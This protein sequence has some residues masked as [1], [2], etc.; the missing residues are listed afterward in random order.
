LL[1][2]IV[3]GFIRVNVYETTGFA[4]NAVQA[5][6]DDA[7]KQLVG[8]RLTDQVIIRL[9]GPLQEAEPILSVAILEAVRT[10]QFSQILRSAAVDA[11]R[12][13]FGKDTGNPELD[14]SDAGPLI[15]AVVERVDPGLADAL[16]ATIEGLLVEVSTKPQVTRLIRI[17]EDARD[18]TF[19]WPSLAIGLFALGILIAPNRRRCVVAVGVVMAVAGLILLVGAEALRTF[20]L[21]ERTGSTEADAARAIADAYLDDAPV[22]GFVIAVAGAVLA[23]AAISAGHPGE[24]VRQLRRVSHAITSRPQSPWLQILRGLVAGAVAVFVLFQRDL[25]V[26]IAVVVAGFLLLLYALT[27][28]MRA[29]ERV[30][31]RA[32]GLVPWLVAFVAVLAIVVTGILVLTP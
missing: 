4:D 25:A 11:N 12:V 10:P 3:Y 8:E 29:A 6:R 15:Q 21:S 32:A 13:F 24:V 30:S 1:T 14:L 31:G 9:P 28:V 26:T 5:F 18:F 2:G 22:W 16:P 27:E 23:A 17:A 19:L 20:A 7:V